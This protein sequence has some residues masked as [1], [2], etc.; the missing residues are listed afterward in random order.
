M[1]AFFTNR[2][3]VNSKDNLNLG[4][5]TKSVGKNID[6][7]LWGRKTDNIIK[8]IFLYLKLVEYTCFHLK[9]SQVHMFSSGFS[10]VGIFCYDYHSKLVSDS[11]RPRGFLVERLS[12]T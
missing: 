2:L 8:S 12:I 4:W 6:V 9:T 7:A 11:A 1:S 10:R 3:C 5:R